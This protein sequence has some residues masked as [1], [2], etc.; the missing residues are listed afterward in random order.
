MD[1]TELI[2][3]LSY[4][5][6]L[7]HDAARAYEKALDNIETAAMRDSLRQFLAEHERHVSDLADAI[8][9]EGGEPPE[10]A[11]D[12]RGVFL[13]A[14]SSVDGGGGENPVL[15]GLEAGERYVNY[16]YRHVKDEDFPAHIGRLLERNRAD[17]RRH[18]AYVESRVRRAEPSRRIGKALGL[19][20]LGVA[21]GVVILLQVAGR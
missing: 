11:G 4:F 16:K 1:R 15:R 12:A 19:G 10:L 17:E 21:A 6:R 3:R 14:L 7:D 13:G 5:M 8:R 9:K 20:A 2:E 18:L